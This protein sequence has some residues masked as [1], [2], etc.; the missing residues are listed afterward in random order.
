MA[1]LQGLLPSG[2]LGGLDFVEKTVN[3]GVDQWGH[4]LGRHTTGSACIR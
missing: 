1:S 2:D 3:T 4:D